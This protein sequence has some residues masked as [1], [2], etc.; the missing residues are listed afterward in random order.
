MCVHLSPCVHK[1][2][3]PE[4]RVS[5]L[6]PVIIWFTQAPSH[7]SHLINEEIQFQRG[8]ILMQG[9]TANWSLKGARTSQDAALTLSSNGDNVTRSAV[10]MTLR[11]TGW[12]STVSSEL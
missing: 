1:R 5:E 11:W 2:R 6:M 12:W 4:H 9:H 8:Q 10:S 3:A 7:S